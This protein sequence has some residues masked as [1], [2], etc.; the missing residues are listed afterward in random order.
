MFSILPSSFF[1]FFSLFPSSLT[2]LHVLHPWPSSYPLP[3]TL[4]MQILTT[5]SVWPIGVTLLLHWTQA[6]LSGHSRVYRGG[7]RGWRHDSPLTQHHHDLGDTGRGSRYVG[8]RES[9]TLFLSPHS[10]SCLSVYLL[11]LFT[12][13]CDKFSSHGRIT[14]AI[15][16]RLGWSNH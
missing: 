11:C 1:L 14:P 2:F 4:N 9:W 16:M 10:L 5:G 15:N 13:C 7:W 8:M 12:L 3:P 6:T